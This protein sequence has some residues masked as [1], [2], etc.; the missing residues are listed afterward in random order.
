MKI[1]IRKSGITFGSLVKLFSVGYFVGVGILLVL[2]SV[3]LCYFKWRDTMPLFFW[4]IF[5]IL[6][7]IQ[8]LF[9]AVVVA[10]GLKLYGKASKYELFCEDAFQQPAPPDRR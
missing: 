6:F 5:P 4:L 2:V 7:A 9:T 8:S 10:A 3:P 1:K